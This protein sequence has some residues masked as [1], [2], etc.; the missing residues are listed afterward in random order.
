[1]FHVSVC[2]HAPWLMNKYKKRETHTP[3]ATLLYHDEWK[4]DA[5]SICDTKNNNNNTSKWIATAIVF[6]RSRRRTKLATQID[7]Q[8]VNTF[9]N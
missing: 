8:F 1:M 9:T 6:T 7:K 4:S 2:V 3:H 5:E